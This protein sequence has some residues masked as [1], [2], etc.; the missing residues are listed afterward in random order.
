MATIARISGKEF[1][2]VISS[3][4]SILLIHGTP[5]GYHI[6]VAAREFAEDRHGYSTAVVCTVKR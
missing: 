4:I 6:K 1:E 5:N 2:V 3:R